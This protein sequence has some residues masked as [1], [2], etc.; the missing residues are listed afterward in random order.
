MSCSYIKD[1]L[2]TFQEVYGQQSLDDGYEYSQDDDDEGVGR[3]TSY[4]HYQQ[5][6]A[7]EP[8]RRTSHYS[9]QDTSPQVPIYW[10]SYD[11]QYQQGSFRCNKMDWKI[12]ALLTNIC[13][14]LKS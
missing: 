3:R 9:N 12:F 8:E 13:F 2:T 6:Q 5:Q 14:I 1:Q 11:L 4:Q 10:R 7:A